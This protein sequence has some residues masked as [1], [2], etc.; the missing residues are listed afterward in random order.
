M[1]TAPTRPRTVLVVDD[2]AL[3]R[4]LAV[5]T[6]EHSGYRVFE[7]TNSQEAIEVLLG[8]AGQIDV[9]MTDVHMSGETNGIGLVQFVEREYP[10]IRSLIVSG[11][12]LWGDIQAAA[13]FL[14]KPYSY[15]VLVDAVHRLCL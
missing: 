13:I 1:I 8:N 6:L 15:E 4:M 14:P 11:K 12:A 7:A 5:E 9:L 2:E 3:I 10:N